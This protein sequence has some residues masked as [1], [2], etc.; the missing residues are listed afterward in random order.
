MWREW[1]RGPIDETRAWTSLSLNLLALPG[2]GSFLVGRRIAGVA[3][4]VL[5]SVGAGLSGWWLILLAGQ[6]TRE[7]YFP[8]DGGDDLRVGVAGVLVFAAAW[9]WSL[10]TSLSV[11]RAVKRPR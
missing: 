9:V 10:V 7:G 5:A 1:A 2:L 11:L 4:A 3:Q 8:I 6:W